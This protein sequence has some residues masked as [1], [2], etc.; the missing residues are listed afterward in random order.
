ME[1]TTRLLAGLLGNTARVLPPERRQWAE[2]IQAEAG[3][4]PA[5]W[6]Q[7]HWLAGGLWLVAREANM[8]RKIV[9]WLGLGVAAAAA[10]WAIWLSWR[11]VP[12]ADPESVTDRVRILVGAS[13]LLVLPW[14]GRRS[15]L[16]GPV[17]SGITPRLVR[18][19]GCVAICGL[20]VSIVRLDGNAGSSGGVLGSGT[21]SWSR[22]IAG[23][24]LLGAVAATPPVIRALRPHADTGAVWTSTVAMA[25]VA[26]AVMP[27]QV[28]TILY[29]AGILAATSRRSPLPSAALAIG[30]ITGLATGL[31]IYGVLAIPADIVLTGGIVLIIFLILAA[32]PF[33]VAAPAG[34]A[35]AWLLSGIGDPQELRARRVRQGLLA[36]ATAGAAGGLLITVSAMGLGI[37]MIIG[38]L[39]GAAGGMFGGAVAAAHPR[40]SLPGGSRAAGMFVSGP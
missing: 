38:P 31:I 7:L 37:M 8:A 26:F 29:V 21:M 25:A 4:V 20:G 22:E 27:L 12:T 19:A 16:F 35:A 5:G 36:G 17:G 1:R 10:A 34:I 13:A 9:Y 2:A 24:A 3:Q 40:R 28:L 15:G 39:A 30:T 32:I 23:L 14:A 18:V 33:L 11:T 6:R